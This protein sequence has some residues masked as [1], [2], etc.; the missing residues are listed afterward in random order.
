MIFTITRKSLR[1]SGKDW[2]EVCWRKISVKAPLTGE[3][4]IKKLTRFGKIS[5]YKKHPF[6][7]AVNGFQI[8]PRM[9]ELMVYAGQLDCYDRCNE[10]IREFTNV[11]V[12]TTQIYRLTD[13]YGTQIEKE[14][15][16]ESTLPALKKQE[17]L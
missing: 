3:K 8:S 14:V 4:K 15:N 5:I 13:K 11:E 1:I 10:V 12:S 9:Q 6:S 2:D 17:A 16:K 7:K